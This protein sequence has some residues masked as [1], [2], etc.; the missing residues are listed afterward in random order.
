M[1]MEALE[2]ANESAPEHP[3]NMLVN[4]SYSRETRAEMGVSINLPT[5]PFCGTP[6]KKDRSSAA[7]AAKQIS[8]IFKEFDKDFR[9]QYILP[10]LETIF[11]KVPQKQD[12]VPQILG[13][14][15]GFAASC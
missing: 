8:K 13:D 11:S 9:I 5:Y 1:L 12:N 15:I 3:V 2:F 10:Y 6:S 7:M 14:M 4:L